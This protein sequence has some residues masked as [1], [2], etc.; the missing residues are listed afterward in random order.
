MHSLLSIIS[1]LIILT[2]GMVPSSAQKARSKTE[3][4]VRAADQEWLR[5]FAAKDLEKSVAFCTDDGSVLAPNVPIATGKEAIRKLFSGFFALPN[6][7]I[8]W[9]PAKVQVA[10]SGELGYTSGTY[11]MSF[12]DAS[13]KLISDRGKYV[14]VWKRQGDGSWKV[15]LDIFNSDLPMAASS[16]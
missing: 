9:Q 12:N 14:T 13:G 7:N 1:L 4:A 15:L 10:K 6:L 3:D 2:V 8:S 11:Q 5:V 16:P